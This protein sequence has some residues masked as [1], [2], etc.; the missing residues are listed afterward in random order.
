MAEFLTH[1]G[2][3]VGERR[4]ALLQFVDAVLGEAMAQTMGAG[5]PA[6]DGAGGGGE[7]LAPGLAV[8]QAVVGLGVDA[9]VGGGYGLG[10]ALGFEGGGEVRW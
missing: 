3:G 10:Q 8:A 7:V 6:E 4:T 9:A 5:A 2:L 1:Q